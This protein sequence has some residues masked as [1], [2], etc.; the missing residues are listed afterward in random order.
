MV[1]R[2][3]SCSKGYE[4]ISDY[5]INNGANVNKIKRNQNTSVDN[6]TLENSDNETLDGSLRDMN[7]NHDPEKTI[8]PDNLWVKTHY[9]WKTQDVL[10][11]NKC[12]Y[13]S[14]S[15]SEDL[16]NSNMKLVESINLRCSKLNFKLWNPNKNYLGVVLY[17]IYS[18]K[19]YVLFIDKDYKYGNGN[20]FDYQLYWIKIQIL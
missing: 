10:F 9:E 12:I 11:K 13:S 8:C 2:L 16:D 15:K 3:L 7:G 4:E 17:E 14:T 5:L 19:F 20:L 18:K 1:I 6:N